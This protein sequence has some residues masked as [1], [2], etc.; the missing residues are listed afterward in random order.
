MSGQQHS[1]IQAHR[2]IN[3]R[4]ELDPIIDE[5]GGPGGDYLKPFALIDITTDTFSVLSNYGKTCGSWIAGQ[6]QTIDA[7]TGMTWSSDRWN[8]TAITESGFVC[9]K[10]HM[11]ESAPTVSIEFAAGGMPD[12]DDDDEYIPLW[13]IPWAAS[14]IDVDSIVDLRETYRITGMAT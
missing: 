11:D 5:S 10:F 1:R 9:L 4:R 13:Y 7:G 12:G 2:I 8:A 14:K 3:A 6:H